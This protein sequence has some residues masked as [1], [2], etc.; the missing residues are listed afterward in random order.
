MKKIILVTLFLFALSSV[1]FA[2]PLTD[3]SKGNWALDLN[4]RVNN[5]YDA[6]ADV[7]GT[8]FS[9]GKQ[10]LDGKNNLELGLTFSLGNNLAL[11]YRQANPKGDWSYT[12][13]YE[14]EYSRSVGVEAK[15]RVEEY[16]V[17]YKVN[18]NLS[19]FTGYVNAK[20]SASLSAIDG[21]ENIGVSLTGHNKNIWQ[22][23]LMGTVPIKDKLTAYGIAAVGNDYHNLEAGVGYQI[24]KDL[25]FNVNYRILKV[26]K[27]DVANY[28]GYTLTT[29]T[30]VKGWGFGLTQKM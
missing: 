22:V 3:Y 13:T 23:G 14:N 19:A 2:S 12:D 7:T 9:T 24:T 25:D 1:A 5:S 26:E 27:M 21:E 29:D 4:Y 20:P 30:K 16:N 18:K 10:K 15:T 28:D 6:S 11:Q 8:D 17:L